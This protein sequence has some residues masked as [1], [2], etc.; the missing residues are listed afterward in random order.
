MPPALESEV[1]LAR[2][3]R[4]AFDRLGEDLLGFGGAAPAVEL[5]PLALLQVL[6][7]PEEVADALAPVRAD[8]GAV[9][10]VA[11]AGEPLVDRHRQAL[12]VPAR[13]GAHWHHADRGAADP[14]DRDQGPR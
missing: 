10:D 1:L 12:H 3:R 7:V 13:L 9:V 4:V 2:Q 14:P 11:V 5:D 8:L 6:V